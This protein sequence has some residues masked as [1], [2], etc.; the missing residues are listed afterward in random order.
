VSAS[1]EDYVALLE[2]RAAAIVQEF[3]DQK[4]TEDKARFLELHKRNLEAIRKGALITSHELSLRINDM[5]GKVRSLYPQR[6]VPGPG[7]QG[8]APHYGARRLPRTG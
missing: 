2:S 6:D 5:L 7:I 8:S 1:T 4:R 3:D